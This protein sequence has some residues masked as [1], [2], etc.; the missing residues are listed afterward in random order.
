[1]QKRH[2]ENTESK[3]KTEG[4]SNKKVENKNALM[5]RSHPDNIKRLSQLSGTPLSEV[6]NLLK[7][8]S[9]N[10][11]KIEE[12]TVLAIKNGNEAL[13]YSEFLIGQERAKLVRTK[14]VVQEKNEITA[15]EIKNEKELLQSKEQFLAEL[16]NKR[17][18][19]KNTKISAS[20]EPTSV[21]ESDIEKLQKEIIRIRARYEAD[22]QSLLV[23]K[24]NL[25]QE[26]RED[27]TLFV[28]KYGENVIK[29]LRLK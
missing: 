10:R 9:A 12:I 8:P 13:I 7:F 24:K 27:S 16:E 3:R 15:K 25:E 11:A 21:G 17:D 2:P 14:P 29:L 6:E 23:E 19:L 5:C 1:M 18:A 28:E 22:P 26:F 4:F 20:S